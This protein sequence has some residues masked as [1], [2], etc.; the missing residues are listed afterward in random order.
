MRYASKGFDVSLT[1]F[2]QTVDY[3]PDTSE[4]VHQK[5]GQLTVTVRKRTVKPDYTITTFRLVHDE[6]R[7]S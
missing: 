4:V 2:E 3:W 1:V 7:I 6:V 5:Y